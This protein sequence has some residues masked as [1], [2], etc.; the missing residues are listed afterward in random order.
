METERTPS[1]TLRCWLKLF[2]AAAILFLAVL[3]AVRIAH[4]A[5]ADDERAP[6]ALGA[7]A[8]FFQTFNGGGPDRAAS[9]PLLMAAYATDPRD[10]RTN[11]LLGL[12]HL[13]LA[14][15]GD[16]SD[17][18][19]IENVVLAERFLARAQSLNPGDQRIASWLVPIRLSLASIEREP[20][21]RQGEIFGELLAAYQEDPDFHSFS[22]A[23]L[24][25]DRPRGSQEFQRGLEALRLTK[26]CAAE[27]AACRNR[28]KWP[29]N[30]EAFLTFHAD[31][32]LKAGHP[33]RAAE[34]L[35]H[36][37]AEPD[38]PAWPFRAKVEDRLKNLEAYGKLYA[39]EDARDDP[40]SLMAHAGGVTCQSC[41]RAR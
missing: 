11:L 9:L 15:E 32:E 6:A 30:R 21:G 34:L 10:A 5:Q 14:A 39:N 37:Q 22:L 35:R 1:R 18:R 33:D 29:H 2:T 23:L 3:A 16:R 19:T 28:P 40:P 24:S 13:W 8:K 31:Y 27:N 25:F 17:P 41:H 26:G 36:A 38:Y 4:A 12:N 7:E 20:A